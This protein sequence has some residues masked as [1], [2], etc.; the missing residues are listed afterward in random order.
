MTAQEGSFRDGYLRT[1]DVS[2]LRE[3]GCLV[4]AGL[5]KTEAG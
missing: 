1:G 2:H 4:L 5:V 3:D